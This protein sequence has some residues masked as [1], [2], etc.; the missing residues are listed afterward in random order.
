MTCQGV[1][2]VKKTYLLLAVF[3]FMAAAVLL[4]GCSSEKGSFLGSF[5]EEKTDDQ[6]ERRDADADDYDCS[7]TVPDPEPEDL[8]SLALITAVQAEEAALAAYPDATIEEVELDNEN[9]CLVYSVELSN[10]LDVKVDAGN[11]DILR[12]ES[13]DDHDE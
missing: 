4:W 2:I 11:G 1:K 8:S 13:D 12:V 10:A 7:I 3:V 5:F 9:G 6:D